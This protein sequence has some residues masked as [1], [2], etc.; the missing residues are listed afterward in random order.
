MRR[1]GKLVCSGLVVG[2]GAVVATVVLS[3]GGVTPIPIRGGIA[4]ADELPRFTDCT[5]LQTWYRTAAVREMTPYGL[6]GTMNGRFGMEDLAGGSVAGAAP[7]PQAATAGK[8]AVGNGA[9]GTNTL[10][11]GVDEPDLVKT[12]GSHVIGV[13]GNRLYVTDTSGDAPHLMGSLK[14]PGYASELV[15]DGDRALVISGGG[16][17]GGPVGI[18]SKRGYWGGG[19]TTTV[20]ALVDLANPAKPRLLGS[21]EVDGTVLSA[22]L[23]AGT[24]RVVTSSSPSLQ[25]VSP[26]YPSY[27]GRWTPGIERLWR[28]SERVA[29]LKNR[30]LA[31]K[32]ALSSLEPTTTIRNAAG[33]VV[34]TGQ[35]TPCSQVRHPAVESGARTLSV[36]TLQLNQLDPLGAESSTAVIAEGEFVAAST[37]RLYVATSRWG[38]WFMPRESDEVSVSIHAFDTSVRGVTRYA[39]SGTVAGYLLDRSA[40]DEKDGHLR[41]A[42]TRGIP[43]PP[44]GEGTTPAGTKVSESS[45]VVLDEVDGKLTQVGRVDGLGHGEQVRAVRWLGDFAAVVTFQ[46]TDPL[47]LVDLSAP[48]APKL[49][50]ELKLTGYSAYLHPVGDGRLLGIGHEADSR[51]RIQ[52]AQVSLFDVSDLDHPTRMDQELLG[53]G[54]TDAENEPRAFTY[55][56]ETQLAL[57]PFSNYNGSTSALSVKVGVHSLDTAGRMPTPQVN[58]EYGWDQVVRLMPV[59]DKV[60]AVGY[61]SLRLVDPR[62]LDVSGTLELPVDAWNK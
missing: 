39:A 25:A 13:S 53:D 15:L 18:S 24:T 40:I 54:W 51:G 42:I 5:A 38:S 62:T 7:V 12:D 31:R 32:A 56:P 47:Y 60:V 22:R 1:V 10:V 16:W 26:V 37:D 11:E 28:Q 57:L 29:L 20:L 41:I 23:T 2:T 3:G 61:R 55:L 27:N 46:Q 34:R 9:T 8:S 43:S 21:Q 58:A 33:R 30:A 45:V 36:L 59:G 35:L 19:R 6:P 14:L 44:T 4:H 50:G 52:A 48:T 49:R 17:Y